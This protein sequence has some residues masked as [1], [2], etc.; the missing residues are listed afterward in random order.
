MAIERANLSG[1]SPSNSVCAATRATLIAK[2]HGAQRGLAVEVSRL[3][4]GLIVYMQAVEPATG[5]SLSST[6]APVSGAGE[7]SPADRAQ[8]RAAVVRVVEPERYTGR[9]ALHID[10]KGADLQV[11]GRAQSAEAAARGRSCRAR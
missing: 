4:D 6:T 9:V 3:G 7:L 1:R 11:D 2:E 8:L 5:K 10:V